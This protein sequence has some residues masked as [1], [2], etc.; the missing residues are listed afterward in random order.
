MPANPHHPQIMIKVETAQKPNRAI[1][2]SL[3][4]GEEGYKFSI[5]FV[6]DC[7]SK[8]SNKLPGRLM[9]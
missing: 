3:F 1:F 9:K 8:K 4:W 7:R 2:P 5:Y 6:Q